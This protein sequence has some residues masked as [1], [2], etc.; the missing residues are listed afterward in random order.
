MS[1]EAAEKG[2]SAKCHIY[3]WRPTGSRC[4]AAGTWARRCRVC[5]TGTGM[6]SGSQVWALARHPSQPHTLLA[7]TNTGIYRLNQDEN[8]WTHLPSPM[9]D[10][11]LVTALAYAP[12]NPNVI[13]AGTQPA[14][15]YRSE[16]A[17]KSWQNLGVPMKPY[18]LTGY[19]LVTTYFP[20]VTLALTVGS[21]GLG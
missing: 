16:D 11:M 20:R 4:G 3:T 18:A 21:T 13:L 15:F 12:D 10:V 17:G 2:E 5:P 1:S 8:D 9:D 7:G 14:G 19:D 6:Y